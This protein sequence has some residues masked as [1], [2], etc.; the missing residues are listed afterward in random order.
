MHITLLSI[1]DF[2]LMFRFNSLVLFSLLCVGGVFFVISPKQTF[3]ETEKRRLIQLPEISWSNYISG[4]LSRDL[5]AY[6]NDHFLLRSRAIF[7]AGTIR[8]YMGIHLPNQERWVRARRANETKLVAQPD[9]TSIDS[10][11]NSK[12]EYEDLYSGGLL[13]LNGR[14][15]TSN[16]GNPA[17]SPL[18]SRMV[19]EYATSLQ[20]RARVFSCVAPL[21]SGF[22]PNPGYEVYQRRNKKTLEAIRQTLNPSVG[23]CDIFSEMT[24][25]KQEQLWFGSDHHWTALG[26][27]YAY[28]A[29]TKAAGFEAVPLSQMKK[30]IRYPFLGTLY[31]LT[32]DE[33]VRQRPDTVLVFM[34]KVQTEAVRYN[35]NDMQKP[36][37]SSVFCRGSNYYAFLC[38]DYPLIKIKT[39]L[40]NGRKA[41]VIKN[42]MG[43]AFSVY[44]ISHYEE[45][46]I[47]DYR[48]SKHDLNNL[49]AEKGIQDLIFA[50]SMYAAMTRGTI[51]EMRNLGLNKSTPQITISQDSLLLKSL[52]ASTTTTET[53]SVDTLQTKNFP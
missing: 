15:Y 39:N 27:Y 21:S 47:I 38:G 31:E 22:I 53:I 16:T 48:Y 13:I 25:H 7:A 23:Y 29:F 20:N 26:A 41:A 46:Y 51:K 17:I 43:N 24:E 18:F 33:S 14:V 50:V 3:S 11:A 2:D 4:S 28:V 8:Y 45:L 42:S 34:P 40:K 5:N 49:I 12:S 19:N 37:S 36:I 9:S 32:R 35:A 30:S 1:L 6:V 44:L 52:D 10:L